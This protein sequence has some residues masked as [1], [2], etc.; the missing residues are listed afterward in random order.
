MIDRLLTNGNIYTL[1]NSIPRATT[2]AIRGEEIVAVGGDELLALAGKE[3]R[4]DDLG[5]AMVLPGFCDAHIHWSETALS[6]Q[7]IN[8]FD[9]PNKEE[10]VAE[11]GKAAGKAASGEWLIGHGWAQGIWPVPEFPTAADLDAVTPNNP[12]LLNARSGHAVWVNS[13][14]M[15]L[16]GITRDTE[17]P[18]GG[19]IQ[20]DQQGN[21]TGIFFEDAQSL[22]FNAAPKATPEEIVKAAETAQHHAWASGLTS[23]H[24][25]D[26]PDA[27]TAFRLME[28]RGT[29]GLRVLKNINDPYIHHAMSS[30]LRS[31]FGSNWLRIGGVKMFADGAIGSVTARMFE[32]YN[33]EPDNV[34]ITITPK[35][36]MAEIAEE[37]TRR[38][39]YSV[40]HAIG[41]K[42]VHDVLDIF[43]G[44]RKLEAGLS[45]PRAQRRHRMEHAQV[46]HPHDVPRMGE[47]DI[48]A[49]IQPIHAT[50]D[51]PMADRLLGAKRCE[52]SYN[53]KMFLE[54]GARVIFG[55]DCP[56]EPF[57][58]LKGIHAAVTRR[59]ADGSPGPEGW[60]PNA[61]ISMEEAVRAYTEVPAYAAGMEGFLGKLAPR[62]L[63]DIVVMDNDLFSMDANELLSVKVLGTMSGG[64]WRHGHWVTR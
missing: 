9:F 48:I 61:R 47:L 52:T 16:A 7:Q 55:S 36:Q 10:C 54:T 38:G 22:L 44:L 40:V 35:D 21:P 57:E 6:L 30:G 34:G 63:A 3:T 2:L 20:R 1:D 5:G 26:G 31:G 45:I 13:V 58:P 51:Y 28:E 59:R 53:P 19:E 11:V 64:T 62:F 39:I 8:L 56:V 32:A 24:D 15:K 43:E 42:A 41:D 46:F 17:D 37:C 14:A 60:Y 33:G 23:M 49:S 27:F 4:I 12:V 50:A 29:L 18:K 25:M